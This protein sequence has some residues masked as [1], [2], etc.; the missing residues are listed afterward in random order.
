MF[1]IS[2]YIIIL[3]CVLIDLTTM[4]LNCFNCKGRPNISN[5][6]FVRSEQNFNDLV[7]NNDENQSD[8]FIL[9][10]NSFHKGNSFVYDIPILFR[11][12]KYVWN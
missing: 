7:M 11:M 9:F 6:Q 5:E 8:R 4:S 2:A 10:G 3:C 1:L 12:A